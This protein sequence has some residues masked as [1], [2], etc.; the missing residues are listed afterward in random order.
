MEEEK[1]KKKEEE[2]ERKTR[3][4][5]LSSSPLCMHVWGEEE[6]EALPYAHRH[7]WGEEEEEMGGE[8]D[9][10][11]QEKESSIGREIERKRERE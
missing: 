5:R 1:K 10:N 6:E 9:R 2:E 7:A 4:K 11:I 3:K 8:R